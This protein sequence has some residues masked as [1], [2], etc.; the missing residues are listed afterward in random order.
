MKIVRLLPVFISTFLIA[1]HFQRAG[2]TVV[3]I[4]CLF[5]LVLL[6]V[7]QPWS[8]LLIQAF[9]ILSAVEWL[10]TL[11]NLVQIRLEYGMPWGRLAFILGC[12]AFFT[13]ISTLIFRHPQ[14]QK[15]YNGR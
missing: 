14:I 15:K 10:R 3:A 2:L 5:A 4:T 8:I 6:L 12:V 11:I 7:T 9:L 1:A 13:A